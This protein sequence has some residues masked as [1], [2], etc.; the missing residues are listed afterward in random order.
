MTTNETQAN[1][2]TMTSTMFAF[3]IPAQVLFDFGS[4]RS[5][6][7]SAFALHT[8][9]ELAP[10]KNKLVVTTFL[11]EQILHNFVFKGCEILVDGVVLKVNL[12]SLEIHDFDVIL[13]MN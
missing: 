12:I 13:G 2:N 7:S 11:G 8:D 3:G 5:F 9:H 4:N 1:S 6:V 10:L